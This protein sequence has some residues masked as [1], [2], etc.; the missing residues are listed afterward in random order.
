MPTPILVAVARLA[1]DVLGTRVDRRHHHRVGVG[2]RKVI[3]DLALALEHE[4]DRSRLAKVAAVLGECRA[5]HRR[6]AVAVVGHR[7]DDDG[8]ATGAI[9][10]VADLVIGLG[11]A[12]DRLLDGT[13]DHVLG[14]RDRL[15][16]LDGQSQARVLVWVRL[17]HAGRHGD[18]L[19]QLGELLGPD[20]V[21]PPLAVL[22]VCPFGMAGHW[23][24]PGKL[25][26]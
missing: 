20:R 9:A 15:G 1:F 3:D 17:A 22:D 13:V 23:V 19:G 10:F 11:V 4:A 12:T 8:D 25:S 16:L 6:G 5:H 18:L 21:L 2:G 24:L 7:L 26:G 14:D